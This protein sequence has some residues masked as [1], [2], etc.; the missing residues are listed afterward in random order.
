[1]LKKRFLFFKDLVS[2]FQFHHIPDLSAQLSF[3]FLL[4]LFPFLIFV[5]ALLAYTPLTTADVLR[6]AGQYIP[7]QAL[8]PISENISGILDVQRGGLMSISIIIALWSAS[9]GSHA[10]IRALNHAYSVEESRSF[11]KARLI[12]IMLTFALIFVILLALLLPVFGRAIGLFI[13]SVIGYT[14][15]FL[16]FWEFIRWGI[17]LTIIFMIFCTLYYVAPNIKLSWEEIWVGAIFATLGWAA[18]SFGYSVYLNNF[19]HFNATYGSLGGVIGLLLWFFLTAMTLILGG[20]INA[21]LRS[22]RNER[23]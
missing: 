16:L 6:V 20:E 7:T 2:R 1:M 22:W 18:I 10:I 14:E 12:A 21:T 4:A 11:I 5:F 3:Y 19:A 17:S 9:N 13:F 15:N 8:E 23:A